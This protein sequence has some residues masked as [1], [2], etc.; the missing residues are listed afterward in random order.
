MSEFIIGAIIA[1]GIMNDGYVY[2]VYSNQN[3]YD[4]T[5]VLLTG[6]QLNF[7]GNWLLYHFREY[8]ASQHNIAQGCGMMILVLIDFSKFKNAKHFSSD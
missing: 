8:N 7:C 6:H 4:I 1:T 5:L 3:F 2:C